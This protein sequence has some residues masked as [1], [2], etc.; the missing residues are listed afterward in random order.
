MKRVFI[1][2]GENGTR[3]ALMEGKELREIY[4]DNRQNTSWVGRVIVGRLQTILP[5]EFAFIDIGTN[6]NAFMNLRPGHGLKAGQPLLVQIQKDANRKKGAYVSQDISLKGRLVILSDHFGGGGAV[7]VSRK[8][9][10]DVE[11]RRLKNLARE[12]IPSGYSVIVR[13]NA[14]GQPQQTLAEEIDALHRL[15]LQ[16]KNR[17]Q[18][19]RPPALLYPDVSTK[20]TVLDDLL[21]ND[22]SEI[23]V[24]GTVDDFLATKAS[25]CDVVPSLAARIFHHDQELSL[26]DAY[27]INRQ[28]KSA[29]EKTV[30]LSCGGT[31][32]FEETEACVVIDVNTGSNVGKTSYRETVLHT[33]MEAAKCISRQLTLRNLAG[34]ILVDFIDM[35]REEDNAALMDFF[36][37]EM[38]TERIK[39]EVIGMIG[40]GMVQL[41]RRKTRPS[42]SQLLEIKCPHC[43]GKGSVR[44]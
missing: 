23:Y 34:I 15:H 13:T 21:A 27:N 38:N 43:G 31:C 19:A 12:L 16:I 28:I 8:I 4:F 29:L 18:Y 2:H 33:N 10:D 11:N 42:L 14:E 24:S 39:P 36:V 25:V 32:T 5:G 3:T 35:P 26:F 17:A 30:Q 9:V 22:L 6:K 37:Q 7:G 40:L 1:D 41:T 44:R 20:T